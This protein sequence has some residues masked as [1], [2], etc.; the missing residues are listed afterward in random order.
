MSQ[1]LIGMMKRFVRLSAVVGGVV[2]A[3]GRPA[4]AQV[5]PPASPVADPFGPGAGISAGRLVGVVAD[6]AVV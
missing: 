2:L 1:P 4:T 6:T 3:V 5:M